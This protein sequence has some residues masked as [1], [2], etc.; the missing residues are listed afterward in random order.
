[1][2]SEPT[3]IQVILPV[4]L[5]WE[6][7]YR[8][9]ETVSV[10]Q[11]V[12]VALSGKEHI[13]VVSRV[14]ITPDI[15]EAKIKDIIQI[16]KEMDPISDSELALW[17][18][19]SSYYLCSIGETY[20]AAYPLMKTAN[21]KLAAESAKR[22]ELRAEKKKSDLIDKVRTDISRLQARIED[23]ES[24][25]ED[26]SSEKMRAK[27]EMQ[28]QELK[29]KLA[30]KN[31]GLEVVLAGE[32]IAISV[33]G[34]TPEKKETPLIEP[35]LSE[36]QSKAYSEINEAFASGKTALLEGITGSGKTEIYITLAQDALKKGKNVL[37]LVP[38]IALSRQLQTR[39]E[40]AFGDHLLSFHSAETQAHKRDVASL[41]RHNEIPYVII[42]TRSSI[43][44]PHH[45]LGLIIVDEE[46][47][48]SYKQDSPSPRYNGRDAAI[49]L[50]KICSCPIILGSATPSLESLYNC[51]TKKYAHVYL[52]ERYYDAQ[53][54]EIE[55]ID[56]TA[57]RKKRGMLGNFSK[58]LIEHINNTLD[59]NGQVILLRA[60]RSYSPV[61]QCE[62]CGDI[63][64]CPSC[65]VTLSLHKTK[66]GE[67]LLC[68]YCGHTEA[69]TGLC[70]KCGSTY[71][72]LGAGTQKIEE[73]AKTLF[74]TATIARLDSDTARS[75][76]FETQAI[77]DFAEGK[78]NILI[79]TQIVTK[80]FDFKDLSLVAVIGA[81]G[82]LAQQD[83][84]ADE[85]AS[86]LLTQFRGRCGRRD[87]KGL[88]VIQTSQP[89]HPVYT[90]LESGTTQQNIQ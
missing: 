38:E 41:I 18:N 49:M 25:L 61:V 68:H 78:T 13:G 80:G 4:K 79:G 31:S 62:E 44:L 56:T 7:C 86:Q 45:D 82:I 74:P 71:K 64:K 54:A 65:N 52:S 58:K 88:F 3:Y 46:H 15:D 70:S 10:G 28:I 30:V 63:P 33:K 37:Y 40:Q 34:I 19:V 66:A 83:F 73:E 60:R 32:N 53:D 81:D 6:P 85:R 8:V 57:E 23:K 35:T 72:P 69:Y 47:D 5:D 39:L 21:E 1:M 16:E 55:I 43:F 59:A 22:A 42:G 24:K 89:D 17:R 29:A 67:K 12:K 87:K 76:K 50:A 11:R 84:R 20:K 75:S 51:L 36:A 27:L 9:H 26:C 48:S 90:S 14:G 77:K 2:G